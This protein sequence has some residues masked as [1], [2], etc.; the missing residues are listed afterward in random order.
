M[1]PR[2]RLGRMISD[3]AGACNDAIEMSPK[4]GDGTG[5]NQYFG[6]LDAILKAIFMSTAILG[7]TAWFM[8]RS[9]SH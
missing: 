9:D 8:C 7:G 6:S 3:L 5:S 1:L 2:S 4:R